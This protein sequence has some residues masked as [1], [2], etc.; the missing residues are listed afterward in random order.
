MNLNHYFC[1][2]EKV[3]LMSSSVALDRIDYFKPKYEPPHFVSI[4]K[5]PPDTGRLQIQFITEYY[6]SFFV[7]LFHY[8]KQLRTNEWVRVIANRSVEL[9]FPG[10]LLL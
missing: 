10:V 5:I 2:S 7:V 3:F 1:N 4:P 8:N 6:N 9:E